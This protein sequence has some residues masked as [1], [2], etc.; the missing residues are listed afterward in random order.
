MAYTAVTL[1]QLQQKVKDRWERAPF[2]TDDEARDGLNEGLRIWN[3]LTMLWKDRFSLTIPARD[4]FVPLP[5]PLT[6]PARVE[7]A[8]LPLHQ[9]SLFDLDMGRPGWQGETCEELGKT[10][11]EVWAPAGVLMIAVWPPFAVVSPASLTVD[12]CIH[13]PQLYLSTDTVDL[14]QAQEHVLCGYAVHYAA[15]KQGGARFSATMS[16]L[17]EFY[18]GAADQSDRAST[19]AFFREIMGK[20]LDRAQR[21]TRKGQAQET[22]A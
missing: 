18:A 7:Y 19:S 20:D 9:T 17:Q 6:R 21:P 4:P 15:F 1:A 3:L 14:S 8:G 2:W 5:A 10:S 12:G 11:P 16:F 13:T 22:P